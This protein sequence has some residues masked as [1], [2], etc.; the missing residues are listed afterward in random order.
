MF[1][2]KIYKTVI[3]DGTNLFV[4]RE[5]TGIIDMITRRRI[6]RSKWRPLDK[7]HPTMKVIKRFT[8]VRKYHDARRLIEKSYPGLCTFDATI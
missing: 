8:S 1:G 4:N 5:I 2:Y 6:G 3:M 7:N